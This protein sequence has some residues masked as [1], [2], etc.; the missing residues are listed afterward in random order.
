VKHPSDVVKPE[1]EVDVIILKFDK[2]KQRVSLGMKQLMADPWVGA[3]E[4]YPAGGKVKGKIVGVVDYGVFVELEQG[5]E[6]LVH[7]SE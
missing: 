2:E 1:Q 6:G 5:I 4:K 3:A 7:V